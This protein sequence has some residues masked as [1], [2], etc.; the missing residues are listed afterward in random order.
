MVL[1]PQRWRQVL[2]KQASRGDG[3]KKARSPGRA[4]RKPLKPLRA[5]MP[6]VSGVTVVTT[7]VLS[8]LH[9]RLRVHGHPAFPTPS[10]SG[11]RFLHNSGASRREN[12]ESRICNERNPSFVIPGWARA[13][14]TQ[15]SPTSAA[16][17]GFDAS[18]RP[19]MTGLSSKRLAEEFRALQPVSPGQLDRLGDADPH[20]GD[21]FGL[22]R[23]RMQR[24]RRRV[25]RQPVMRVGDA[26]RL[27]SACP[28]PSTAIARRAI[29]AGAASRQCR[30][31]APA[32]GSAPRWPSLLS[33]RR[34]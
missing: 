24:D 11:G 7:R 1:T 19:G 12:A 8:T 21:D 25:E 33:R 10:V 26:E 23:P 29:R 14:D 20:A 4:R 13:C 27:A 22:A 6:G 9:T 3:D 15:S 16:R 28:G 31:S 18:H 5:G 17:F 2:E 32:R 34:N 30:G